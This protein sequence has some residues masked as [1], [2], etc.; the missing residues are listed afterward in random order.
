MGIDV[1]P[2][3]VA[4]IPNVPDGGGVRAVLRWQKEGAPVGE[5]ERIQ[6]S[7]GGVLAKRAS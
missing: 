5:G 1:E 4:R 7:A 2:M 6:W 3:C